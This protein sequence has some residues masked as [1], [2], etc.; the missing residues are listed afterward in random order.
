MILWVDFQPMTTS[1][2]LSFLAGSI[3]ECRLCSAS[4][5]MRMLPGTPQAN[6]NAGWQGQW[7]TSKS[8]PWLLSAH[9]FSLLKRTC[10]EQIWV[11]GGFRVKDH[12]GQLCWVGFVPTSGCS[13]SP[14]LGGC[15][16]W[17]WAWGHLSCH[18]FLWCLQQLWTFI[19]KKNPSSHDSK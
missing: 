13:L 14:A 3:H 17:L 11:C 1:L 19:T 12:R 8:V 16:L 6:D 2:Q 15:R 4:A 5:A 7:D 18:I 9:V 10:G